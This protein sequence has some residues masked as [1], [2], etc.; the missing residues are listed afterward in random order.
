MSCTIENLVRESVPAMEESGTVQ[1]AVELMADRNVGS[2]VVTRS[3]EV[4]GLFTERDLIKRVVSQGRDPR[5]LTLDKVCTCD[6]L[7]ISHETSC[8][9]A[10]QMM[11]RNHCRSLLVYRNQEF[12]GLVALRDIAPAV[13]D[14]GS[15]RNFFVNL[16]GTIT[17][18]VIIAVILMLIY[19]LPEMMDLAKHFSRKRF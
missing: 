4:A 8:Q 11:R 1:Q 2:L 3:G 5:T 6:L 13:A 10:I 16:V 15:R 12:L 9:N 17:F 7:T 14:R 19:N 18:V